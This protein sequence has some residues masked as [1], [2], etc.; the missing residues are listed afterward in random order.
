MTSPNLFLIG[1]PKCGTTSLWD[2]LQTHP[3]IFVPKI[4]EPRYLCNDLH[5]NLALGPASYASLFRYARPEHVY[6]AD[7]STLYF[8]SDA[9][10]YQI[11]NRY[12]DSRVIVCLRNPVDWVISWHNQLVREGVQPIHAFEKAFQAKVEHLD[13]PDRILLDYTLVSKLGSRLR[14][15]TERIPSHRIHVILLDDIARNPLEEY[16]KI[17]S[18]LNLDYDGRIEF[19]RLNES[20]LPPK[21]VL[22]LRQLAR[23]AC[24]RAGRLSFNTNIL[25]VLDRITGSK[26]R[27]VSVDHA[28]RKQLIEML[29]SEISLIEQMLDRDLHYWRQ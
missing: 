1:A 14:Y 15:I 11:T 28:T 3:N 6:R 24:Q 8:F 18:F 29:E 5:L 25:V 7:C 19:P 17:L 20:S 10:L 21:P 2:W 26:N 27:K 16:K 12:P 9:A 4:K 23:R 22:W 13:L